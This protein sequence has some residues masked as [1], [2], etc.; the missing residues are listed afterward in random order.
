MA[1]FRS[2]ELEY[3]YISELK[4]KNILSINRTIYENKTLLPKWNSR[5]YFENLRNTI[6]KSKQIDLL[7]NKKL[8]N[9]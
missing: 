1:R 5:F 2:I 4:K 7:L 9:F 3:R 8:A 6:Y